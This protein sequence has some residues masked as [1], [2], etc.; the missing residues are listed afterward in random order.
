MSKNFRTVLFDLDGT[1]TDS[2]A[3]ILNCVR[4]ALEKMNMEIPDETVLKKFLGPPLVDSFKNY[5]DFTDESAAEAVTFYREYF[6]TKGLLENAVYNGITELLD[7]L[8]SLDKKLIVATS[9][10][11][12]FTNRILEHFDL[13]KYFDFAAG[14]KL[15]NTRC[16]KAEVISY[17]L[18]SCNITDLSDVVM[19][20]DREHDIIGAN[21]IGIDSIGVLYGYGSLQELRAAGATHIAKNTDDILNIIKNI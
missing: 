15:D 13:M 6:S 14:S 7:H 18:S 4:Y 19:I 8:K 5:F 21:D 3:S 1:L 2:S 20:G 17:A 16:K 10:P 9:K 12:P 11:E